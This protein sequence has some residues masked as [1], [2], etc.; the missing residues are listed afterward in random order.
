[1]LGDT[2]SR[3]VLH[4]VTATGTLDWARDLRLELLAEI[5]LMHSGVKTVFHKTLQGPANVT[6]GCLQ[7]TRDR[8][9][10]MERLI[11]ILEGSVTGG[12]NT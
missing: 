1:M 5:E 11:A 7:D 6:Q 2:D 9:A 3:D 10:Q 8:F 12:S 4:R